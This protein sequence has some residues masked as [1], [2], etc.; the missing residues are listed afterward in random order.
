VAVTFPDEH[1]VAGRLADDYYWIAF[2]ERTG[3]SEVLEQVAALGL[4]AAL[5]SELLL[6]GHLTIYQDGL[7]PQS[8]DPPADDLLGQIFAVVSDP[9]QERHVA[10][11]LQFLA[12]EAIADVRARMVG[13]GL[14]GRQAGRSLV[15]KRRTKYVPVH[16]TVAAWPAVRLAKSL[17]RGVEITL[18]EAILACL[19]S[20]TGLMNEI[21]W[22][23]VDHA[24]GWDNLLSIQESMPPPF[25]AV[26]AHTDAAVGKIFLTPRGV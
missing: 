3:R 26:I 25:S 14:L 24:R 19:V 13:S 9:N 6:S 20:A 17:T 2:S 16:A 18:D 10:T 8:A 11:W 5:M 12:T 7:Y 4:A 23:K 15:G 1:V 21:L 22:D